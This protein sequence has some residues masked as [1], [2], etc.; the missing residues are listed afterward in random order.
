MSEFH[1]LIEQQISRLRRYARALRHNRDRAD[2]LVQ[3]T[4]A[5]ALVKEG[6]WQPGS[7]LR[8]W[9]FTIMHNEHVNTVRRGQRAQQLGPENLGLGRRSIVCDM[10]MPRRRRSRRDHPI[11]LLSLVLL[12]SSPLSRPCRTVFG[13]YVVN[14]LQRR[15]RQY[16]QNQ[17]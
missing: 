10:R 12:R 15:E 14:W 3:D 2:D 17:L 8:A 16:L 7:N 13:E 1:R 6:F 4:P 11:Q 9:L 5:R